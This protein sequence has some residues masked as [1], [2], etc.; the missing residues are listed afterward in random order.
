M[1]FPFDARP[2]ELPEGLSPVP[3]AGGAEEV[4]QFDARLAE[5]DV[6]HEV[7][8]YPGAPHCFFDRHYREHADACEDAWRRVL[9]FL[10]RHTAVARA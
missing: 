10:E 2:P 7:A 1:C 6:N 9:G 3:I 5:A 4:E 8:V